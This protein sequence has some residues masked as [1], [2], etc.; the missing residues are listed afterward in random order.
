[1][2]CQRELKDRQRQTGRRSSV[3]APL[4]GREDRA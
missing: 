1:L 3:G 2:S 4:S